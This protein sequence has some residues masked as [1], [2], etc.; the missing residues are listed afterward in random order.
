MNVGKVW[1]VGAGPGDPGLLTLRGREVLLDADSVVFDRLVGDGVLA[2]IP[3]SARAIDVGKEGGCHPVPQREIEE[4]LVREAQAGRKVVRL[5]GGDPFVFG[6][7]GEEIEAL[8]KNGIPFE[9]VPGI[10][11]AMAAPAAAGI[12][13]TH[14]G[15]A[16]AV[17]I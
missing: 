8:L 9:A 10:S 5:K 14:R 7:G 13:V 16:A 4:I 15:L 6:R 2:M 17:H 11:S 1:L 3:K 12:P